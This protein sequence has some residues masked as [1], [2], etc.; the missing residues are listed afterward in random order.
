MGPPPKPEGKR[1]RRNKDGVP[2][3]VL[4]FKP[5]DQPPLP[6]MGSKFRWPAATRT[7]WAMWGDS[8]QAELM[9]AT[10]W[11]FLVDTAL[12][13]ALFW[14]GRT[15]LGAEL[16]LRVAKFGATLEDRARLRITF[17][18]ADKADG[19]ERTPPKSSRERRGALVSMP[20]GE[21]ASGATAG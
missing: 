4:T 1:A 17:A 15:D 6:R 9:T 19:V 14:S 8:A 16:R 20:T 12:I 5:A 2:G 3:T 11:S 18:D 10:D 21:S 13:H 7:W